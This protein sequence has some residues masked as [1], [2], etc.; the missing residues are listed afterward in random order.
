MHF[1]QELDVIC[2]RAD[3]FFNCAHV[4]ILNLFLTFA[5]VMLDVFLLNLQAWLLFLSAFQWLQFGF[6][7]STSI[8]L[9]MHN[10]KWMKP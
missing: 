10:I 4:H 5:R 6:H 2:K 9:V 1:A 3:F 7:I 8:A